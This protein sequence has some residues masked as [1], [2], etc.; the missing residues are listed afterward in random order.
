M[1]FKPWSLWSC[2][3]AVTFSFFLAALIVLN[4]R[5]I[6]CPVPV[7]Y[8]TMLLSYNEA[9]VESGWTIANDYYDGDAYG[10][11]FVGNV[12]EMNGAI[13][14]NAEDI[15]NNDNVFKTEAALNEYITGNN[16]TMTAFPEF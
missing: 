5:L 14:F 2:N 3:S 7:L 12:T 15:S 10:Y 1:Y 11:V 13:Q 8:A 9:K 4:T 16:Y 6:F